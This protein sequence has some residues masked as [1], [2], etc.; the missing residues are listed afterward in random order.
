MQT[1]LVTMAE[2]ELD[3]RQ[4]AFQRWAPYFLL[5][6][7]TL[8][9]LA[10]SGWLMPFDDRRQAA[11]ALVGT[12]LV[13]QLWWSWSGRLHRGPNAISVTYYI[14][15]WAI[16]FALTILNGF[17]AF[18]VVAGYYDADELIPGRKRRRLA[19]FACTIPVAGAQTGG[20]PLH[21][22][23][24]LVFA[25]LVVANNVLLTVV[26]HI[27][28]QQEARSRARADTITELQ[29]AHEENAALQA[30]LLVQAREAGIADER[31]RLAAEIHDTI[32]Q[33]LTGIIAQLQAVANTSDP[34]V[35][36]DRVGRA[37]ELARHSLGE[38]RRSVQNL[39]PAGLS[40]DGLPEAMRKTVD[41]WSERTGVPSEFTLTGTAQHL[42]GEFSA[43]LLRITQEALANV[44]KHA[45][46]TRVGVTLSFMDDEVTVDI[47]DD[48]KGFDPLALPA[49]SGTGGFGL[50]GMRARAERI[51]GSLTVEAEPGFGTAISAHV[52]LVL[53][54]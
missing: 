17:F 34:D 45:A 43:T 14:L 4:A 54:A 33:G 10:A 21:G 48:G 29:Q 28:D 3:R 53:H 35:V 23:G 50:E 32:A 11:M 47:R 6:L 42:H 37:S 25:G 27:A 22:A 44:S 38:A 52:P 26:K 20:F 5:G 24:W 40:Y 12:A 31:R 36:Q 7:G 2:S 16:G 9:A 30:Q 51:A 41:Q 8:L 15:R 18:Y 49:R 1:G 19:L 13:M 46:A 39:A